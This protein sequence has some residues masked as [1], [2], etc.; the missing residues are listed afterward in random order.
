MRCTSLA[1]LAAAIT[2]CAAQSAAWDIPAYAPP[3]FRASDT[4]MYF[5]VAG[6]VRDGASLAALPGVSVRITDTCDVE[7]DADGR[8]HVRLPVGTTPAIRFQA[9]GYRA[10]IRSLLESREGERI[11][12]DIELT[13]EGVSR[14]GA[15]GAG[16]LPAR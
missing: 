9:E 16:E 7:T 5:A 1:V 2:G 10:E 12:L 6:V 11:E 14:D 15:R 13:P 4:A 3:C 8:Y